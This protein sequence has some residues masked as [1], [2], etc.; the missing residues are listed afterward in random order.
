MRDPDMG[1]P[2]PQMSGFLT[3]NRKDIH[4]N[5]KHRRLREE[6]IKCRPEKKNKPFPQREQSRRGV[7]DLG[8]KHAPPY[9]SGLQMTAAIM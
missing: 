3:Q 5:D 9:P 2:A 6:L 8:R 7:G 4:Y 1:M